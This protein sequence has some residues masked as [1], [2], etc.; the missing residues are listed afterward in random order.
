MQVR[1]ADA[2]HKL[3]S[4]FSTACCSGQKVYCLFLNPSSVDIPPEK[5]L[6][7]GTMTACGLYRPVPVA[8]FGGISTEEGI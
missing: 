8:F 3:V 1:R 5:G 6:E 2:L 4:R 7:T